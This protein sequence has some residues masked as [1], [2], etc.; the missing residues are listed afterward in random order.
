MFV[1]PNSCLGQ[2]SQLWQ[3]SSIA[4]KPSTELRHQPQNGPLFSPAASSRRLENGSRQ[5]SHSDIESISH[6]LINSPSA[7][8]QFPCPSDQ[9]KA[10]PNSFAPARPSGTSS[11]M[12]QDN[13]P[14]SVSNCTLDFGR[15]SQ[16]GNEDIHRPTAAHYKYNINFAQTS[17]NARGMLNFE[18]G[19]HSATAASS[20]SPSPAVEEL[21]L[22]DPNSDPIWLISRQ[23][24]VRLCDVYEEEINLSHPFLDMR[25]IRDNVSSLYDSMETLSSHGCSNVPLQRTSIIGSD[26]LKILKMVF[27]TALITERSGPGNIATALFR[28]VKCSV[29]EKFWGDVN[30]PTIIIF[31]LLVSMSLL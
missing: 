30:I 8:A 21:S 26:D 4:Q 10:Y 29:G 9:S 22:D 24:A 12:L 7:H 25:T 6:D 17:L 11:S 1:F 16:P 15:D 13:S 18:R 3:P 14:S 23:E 31:F 27:S 5:V 2:H 28:D 20:R 19:D